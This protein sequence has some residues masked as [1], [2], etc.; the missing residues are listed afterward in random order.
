M[1]H[2]FIEVILVILWWHTCLSLHMSQELLRRICHQMTLHIRR[3]VRLLIVVLVA[4][5][6][7]LRVA[8]HESLLELLLALVPL[9]HHVVGQGRVVVEHAGSPV[10]GIGLDGGQAVVLGG[11]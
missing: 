6:R 1:C 2:L 10:L 7:G 8:R 3:L 11:D 9:H 4:G 5:P